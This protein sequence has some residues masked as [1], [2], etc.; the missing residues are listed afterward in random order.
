MLFVLLCV[1]VTSLSGYGKSY[2]WRMPGI[3]SPGSLCKDTFTTRTSRRRIGLIVWL[4]PVSTQSIP[5]W[6]Q[7]APGFDDLDGLRNFW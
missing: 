7:L 3:L 1:S 2:T 5:L 6:P 4:E